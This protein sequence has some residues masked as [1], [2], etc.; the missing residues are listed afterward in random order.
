MP[1][2]AIDGVVVNVDD[3]F[4]TIDVVVDDAFT[5]RAAMRRRSILIGCLGF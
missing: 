5:A 3:D 1:F 4:D 2:V